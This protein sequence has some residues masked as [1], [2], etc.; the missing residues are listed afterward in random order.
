MKNLLILFLLISNILASQN[1]VVDSIFSTSLDENREF[2]VKLPETYSLNSDQKYPVVYLLDGFSLQNTL[3]TIYDNYWGH[4]LP[5]M[6]LVGISNKNNRTRDLTTSQIKTRRGSVVNVETGG[7]T[8]FTQFIENELIPHIDNTYPTTPYRTIIGHS[9]AGLFTINTLLNHNYLFNNYIA[10][11]PSLDWDNQKLLKEAKEKMV[12][13]N[14]NGKSL[15]VSLAAE[16]LHMWNEEINMLNI[17]DDTSEFTLFARS[18]IEFSTFV[19]SQKQN[20]LSFSWKVYE[21]D[22]HGTVPL[23]SIRDGLVFLF[24]WYQFKSPQKYNN[25]ETSVEELTELLK[26]QEQIYSTNFGYSFPPMIEEMLNGYG[27]MNLQMGQPEKAFVFFKL[28]IEY[29][30]KSPNAYNSM[31]DYYEAQNDISNAIIFTKKATELS[32][33]EYYKNRILELKKNNRR[34]DLEG[35]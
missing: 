7:A 13:E 8:K 12:K 25:P 10:I 4:Y 2:W 33:N 24:K 26:K 16:Q 31:A 5:H 30:P 29:F 15:F 18:I 32:D 22:L 35:Q 3:E 28:N 21:E 6:I 1:K 11:D 14:Y 20:G 23:P 34:D 27:Y 9:Y 17:M 19:K